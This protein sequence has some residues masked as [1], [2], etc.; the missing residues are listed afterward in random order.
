MSHHARPAQRKAAMSPIARDMFFGM[1][2][3][4]QAMDTIMRG[5]NENKQSR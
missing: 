5:S 4:L 2:G 3:I 1:C